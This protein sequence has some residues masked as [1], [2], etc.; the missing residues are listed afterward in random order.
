MALFFLGIAAGIL[1]GMGVGG[2]TL[3]VPALIYFFD[4]PQKIAQGV[5]L[6]AFLPT[7]AAALTTH[8]KNG[9][10]ALKLALILAVSSL[11][12]AVG[13]AWL[14]NA[15]DSGLLS[16]IF[17]IF[18]LAMGLYQLFAKNKKKSSQRP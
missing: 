15:M 1:S 7:A 6:T 16:K 9:Y 13:G 2:G 11:P 4:V 8:Y 10:I 12:G 5:I 14:A 17:G 3:L 18:L